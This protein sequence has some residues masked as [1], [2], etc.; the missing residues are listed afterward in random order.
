MRDSINAVPGAYHIANNP[1]L[2]EPQRENNFELHI[3]GLDDLVRINTGELDDNAI[4]KNA[5]STIN[6][7]LVST[8]VPSFTQEPIEVQYGNNRIKFAGKPRWNEL[9]LVINDY[10]G[11]DGKSA[12]L[13]WQA[14]A[15]KA[16]TQKIGGAADYKKIAYLLEYTPDYKLV[17]SWKLVGAWLSSVVPPSFN[18]EGEGKTVVTATMQYDYALME[19]AE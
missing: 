15:Y 3:M 12:L 4:I 5:G 2:Y 19:V 7:S 11:A 14:I 9:Q 17:R 16:R 1:H 8:T 18:M 10:I 6:Y 13:S